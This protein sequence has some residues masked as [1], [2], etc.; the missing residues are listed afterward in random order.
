M[1]SNP[2]RQHSGKQLT[3]LAGMTMNITLPVKY[4]GVIIASNLDGSL[5]VKGEVS[6]LE[7]RN[8]DE[9]RWS[10]QVNGKIPG[11]QPRE[12][13]TSRVISDRDSQTLPYG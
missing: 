6:Y 4:S 10:S 8:N 5:F 3:S 12:I 11:R 9:G 7:V 13:S 1:S 2:R